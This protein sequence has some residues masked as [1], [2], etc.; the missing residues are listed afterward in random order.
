MFVEN[1][2]RSPA[3]SSSFD[4]ASRRLVEVV[5][6]PLRDHF[7]ALASPHTR[8]DIALLTRLSDAEANHRQLLALA[9]HLKAFAISLCHS[10][11]RADD[12]VQTTLLKA[13]RHRNDFVA[14]TNMKAWLFAILRNSFLS[15][16]RKRKFEVEDQEGGFAD[17]LSV[18]S[19]QL[20]HLAILDLSRALDSLSRDQRE[21]IF[22]ICADG[23]SYEEVATRCGCAI[24]TIKS[25]L[26][27]ARAKLSDVMGV[28]GAHEFGPDQREMSMMRMPH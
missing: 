11:D 22:L 18:P 14:G 6:K 28:S 27:R 23:L 7:E 10:A 8:D 16:I 19:A 26:N 20:G 12:L 15:E 13:W 17:A 9:P 5:A 24:G 3:P 25:R 21:I 4:V 1:V 2:G